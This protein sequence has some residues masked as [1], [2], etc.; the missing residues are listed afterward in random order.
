M[1]TSASRQ[2]FLPVATAS[3]GPR[4]EA[5]NATEFVAPHPP[6]PPRGASGANGRATGLRVVGRYHRARPRRP[7][8]KRG[9]VG[10]NRAA[11]VPPT[12]KTR[13]PAMASQA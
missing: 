2:R 11:E 12:A 7:G 1:N 9:R 4:N 8:A 13:R 3:L 6:G 10:A 5:R